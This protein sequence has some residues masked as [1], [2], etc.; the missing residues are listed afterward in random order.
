M[1]YLIRMEP[2]VQAP[3][4]TLAHASGSCR[5][6]GWLLVQLLR[7]LGLAARFASG[8]LIQLTPDV[9]PLEGPQG[10]SADFTDLHAWCEVYL[11]GAGWIGLD[12]TSGLLAG[13]GHIPLACTPEPSAAAPVGGQVEDC[14]VDVS[15]MRC[16]STASGRLPRVTQ[17]YSEWQWAQIEATG[18]A[19]RC[20]SRGARCAPDD[21]RRADLCFRR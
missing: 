15:S 21:G 9:K 4:E 8:Y 14:E 17:P 3:E 1:R 7:Q 13:E 20:G 11:P 2:G 12:P 18:R 6:S 19:R 10:A 5:D 16:A